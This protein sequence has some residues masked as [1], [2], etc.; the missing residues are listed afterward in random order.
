VRPV[1]EYTHDAGDCSITGGYVYRGSAIPQL[2]GTYIYGDYCTGR[3]WA[4]SAE[5]APRL[6]GLATFGQDA[7]GE[8]YVGST[9]GIFARIVNPNPSP[10]PVRSSPL[11]PDRTPPA[12]RVVTRPFS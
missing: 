2:F 1:L 7:A 10:T 6:P 3:M 8:L 5:L 11:R 12:P 4:G 9:R